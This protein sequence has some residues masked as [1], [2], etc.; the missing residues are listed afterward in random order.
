[1]I[2]NLPLNLPEARRRPETKVISLSSAPIK[3]YKL[4]IGNESYFDRMAE[5]SEDYVFIVKDVT[6]SKEVLKEQLYHG[7]LPSYIVFSVDGQLSGLKEF[8]KFLRSISLLE[9]VPL[10]VYTE[11]ITHELKQALRKLG[12]IDDI[13]TPD[14]AHETF[15]E[16]LSIARS[17]REMARAA[18]AKKGRIYR[19]GHYINYSF[20]RVLDV[21]VAGTALL[22]L[23]P[24]FAIIAV[25]I[26]LESKGP[27]FYISHR[28]GTRYRIFNFYKFRTMVADADQ[29]VA[30][31]THLNQYDTNTTGPVFFKV[32]NDPR[33]TKLGTFL[34]N[35]SLD[36]IPQLLNVIRGDM[37]LVGNRPL[38]L[39][40]AATLTTDHFA[41][42]FNAPAGITGL[43]Q[44]KKRGNKDMSVT[45]RI[46]L[47]I[48]YA[49]KHSVLYDMWILANTPGAMRQKNNV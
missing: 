33:V 41:G 14:I 5:V 6:L 16:K 38:P 34:R 15:A 22:M 26:K 39:Y 31:M 32:T 43:W 29:Q 2:S 7:I 40:E 10:F 48:D 18:S 30:Q 21:A 46:N 8:K 3:R 20:K 9:L 13:I 36:E 47:D 45:E 11:N 4:C 19:P 28:A 49:A 27:I 1:M 25:M 23:S 17:I 44:I 42:R 35:T 24:V 37:S 12:G